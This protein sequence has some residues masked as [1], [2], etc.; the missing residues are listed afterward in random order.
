MIVSI[1]SGKNPL[2]IFRGLPALLST[3]LVQK[4]SLCVRVYNV[5][6][7][8]RSERDHSP[9]K[10]LKRRGKRTYGEID[11]TSSGEHGGAIYCGVWMRCLNNL[12]AI[13]NLVIFGNIVP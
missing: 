7:R 6:L 13:F 5:S 9:I 12:C 2:K 8:Y 11:C 3:S 4:V 10:A 1:N